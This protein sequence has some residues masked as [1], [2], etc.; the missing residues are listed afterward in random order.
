[1]RDLFADRAGPLKRQSRSEPDWTQVVQRLENHVSRQA[2]T[3]ISDLLLEEG[4]REKSYRAEEFRS[5]ATPFEAA[6]MRALVV[7]R[8][9]LDGCAEDASAWVSMGR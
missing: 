4:A 5:F 9:Y 3:P 7:D 8:T 6:Q 1:M 2:G